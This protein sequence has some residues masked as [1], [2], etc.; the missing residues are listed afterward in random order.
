[1]WEF[2]GASVRKQATR[3][4]EAWVDDPATQDAEHSMVLEDTQFRV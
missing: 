1:M 3:K 2:V 4:R